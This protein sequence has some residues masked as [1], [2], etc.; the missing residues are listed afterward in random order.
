MR[1][2]I[3]VHIRLRLPMVPCAVPLQILIL[4]IIQLRLNSTRNGFVTIILSKPL[5][6]TMPTRLLN[7]R[8]ETVRNLVTAFGHDGKSIKRTSPLNRLVVAPLS[9]NLQLKAF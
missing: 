5:R 1:H 4:S 3:V 9:D 8:L 2:P 7:K 6:R